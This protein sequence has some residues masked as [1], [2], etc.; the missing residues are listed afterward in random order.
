M[1]NI[2][3]AV[4]ALFASLTSSQSRQEPG[5]LEKPAAFL[6]QA[7]K[8]LYHPDEGDLKSLAFQGLQRVCTRQNALDVER[9]LEEGG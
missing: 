4:L 6:E 7:E 5:Q 1:K 2:L 8:R 3:P 9:R